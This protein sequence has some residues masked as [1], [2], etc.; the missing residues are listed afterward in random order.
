VQ[1]RQAA[2]TSRG[3][4]QDRSA[5]QSL[6]LFGRIADAVVT[7]PSCRSASGIKHNSAAVTNTHRHRHKHT[8]Y[9][10]GCPLTATCLRQVGLSPLQVDTLSHGPL[11]RL[12]DKAAGETH[13]LGVTAAILQHTNFA[14]FP[15]PDFLQENEIAVVPTPHH[16]APLPCPQDLPCCFHPITQ[17]T[18]TQCLQSKRCPRGRHRPLCT[19]LPRRRGQRLACSRHTQ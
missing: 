13:S 12:R 17:L 16:L 10:Q 3:L 18:C 5:S 7:A 8:H 14:V 4:I 6:L 11:G 9:L 1:H 19:F 15:S 2:H